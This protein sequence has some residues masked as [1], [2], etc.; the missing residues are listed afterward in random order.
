[1]KAWLISAAWPTP[2]GGHAE[3]TTTI[4]AGTKAVATKRAKE[5]AK[6]CGPVAKGKRA[7]V[8]VAER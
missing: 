6:S 7:T 2:D 4:E 5:W 8:T 1:M 3:A